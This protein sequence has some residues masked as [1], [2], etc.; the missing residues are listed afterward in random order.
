MLF[1][2]TT[3]P[4]VPAPVSST[5]YWPFRQK[6]LYPGVAPALNPPRVFPVAPADTTAPLP[7]F[8]FTRLP[9]TTLPV[10][11]TPV[12]STPARPLLLRSL[13][14]VLLPTK[15]LLAPAAIVT[16]LPALPRTAVPAKSV[17]MK[18]YCTLLPVENRPVIRTP[19]RPVLA[20]TFGVRTL[21]PT[22]F[23]SLSVIVTPSNATA[24]AVSP[25]ASRPMTLLVIVVAR[26]Q[27]P[28]RVSPPNEATRAIWAAGRARL[29]TA[30]SSN[31]PS[32][33]TAT[34][35]RPPTVSVLAPMVAGGPEERRSVER[36]L[37]SA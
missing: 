7:A 3:L 19:S 2:D 31:R 22:V 28:P 21:P 33:P 26:V 24:P 20:I 6:L 4:D 8:A 36:K 14:R 37:P 23:P 30:T 5:P 16:P 9:M 15:F 32:N 12:T 13:P 34:P 35:S 29:T 17:P 27:L 10:V 25:S 18:L 11:P 1:P